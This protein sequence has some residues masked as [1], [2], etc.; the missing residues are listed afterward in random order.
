MKSEVL[1][2]HIWA[3]MPRGAV[4]NDLSDPAS[5]HFRSHGMQILQNHL[6][7][8]VTE[9][10]ETKV[11]TMSVDKIADMSRKEAHIHADQDHSNSGFDTGNLCINGKLTISIVTQCVLNI[12]QRAPFSTFT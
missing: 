3:P 12:I 4:G 11:L 7:S 2:L 10:Q 6:Q 9:K 1:V 5:G 8:C